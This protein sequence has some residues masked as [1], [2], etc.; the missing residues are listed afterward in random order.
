VSYKTSNVYD[1]DSICAT[2]GNLRTTENYPTISINLQ[3]YQQILEPNFIYAIGYPLVSGDH[4]YLFGFYS[5]QIYDYSLITNH[6]LLLIPVPSGL[7]E[8]NDNQEINN[9][10]YSQ[11]IVTKFVSTES[12][13]NYVA[14]ISGVSPQ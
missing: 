14:F 1:S 3:P 13:R 10:D 12:S 5:N 9:F 7:N 4:D 11:A 6:E 8:I 2:L